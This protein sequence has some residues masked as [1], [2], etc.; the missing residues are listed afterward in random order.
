MSFKKKPFEHQNL[1]MEINHH[2]AKFV[3]NWS[4]ISNR[5]VIC[6]ISHIKSIIDTWVQTMKNHHYSLKVVSRINIIIYNGWFMKIVSMMSIL[7]HNTL[8]MPKWWQAH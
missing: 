8:L 4:F 2:I 5:H 3:M 1:E 7:T 6:M